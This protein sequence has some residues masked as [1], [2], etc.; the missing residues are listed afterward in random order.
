M[1]YWL[2]FTFPSRHRSN[3]DFQVSSAAAK[4]IKLT[5]LARLLQLTPRLFES[6]RWDRRRN[7]LKKTGLLGGVAGDLG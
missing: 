4:Q 2:N 3:L 6:L 7:E 1:A 5:A